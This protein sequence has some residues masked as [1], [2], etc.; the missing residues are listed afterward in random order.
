VKEQRNSF[1]RTHI[2]KNLAGAARV[3]LGATLAMLCMAMVAKAQ[4]TG[5]LSGTVTDKSGAAVAGAAVVV[6]STNGSATH[7]TTTNGDGAYTVAGLPGG[8]YDV[9]VTATGFQKFTAQKVVL[10]V[11]EKRRIDIQLSV[12]TVSSEVVVTGDSIAQVSTESSEI[13]STITGTQIAEL[14]LNGRNFTQ[15]VNLSPGVVSQ[16]FAN[17]GTDDGVVGIYGNVSFSINGGRSEYNNWELDGGDNMDNGSNATLN[18]YPNPE[19]I[20]EFKVLT[21]SYGAQY[22]RNGSGTVEVET[23]SGGRSFHGSAFEYNR[24]EFFKAKS[25]A[26][27]ECTTCKKARPESWSM[28]A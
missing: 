26:E 25:W 7:I 15:L 8:T 18:V 13:S 12:G 1:Y 17:T 16:Q 19:A 6:S 10:D 14:E 28:P 27:G 11:A 21:S 22:G 20:A 2:V 9:A 23:K 5:Y 24:N 3:L 4:D